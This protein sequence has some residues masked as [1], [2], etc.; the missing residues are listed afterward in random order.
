ME[1]LDGFGVYKIKCWATAMVYIGG[2]SVSF[3]SRKVKHWQRLRKGIHENDLLQASWNKYGEQFFFFEIIVR[4]DDKKNVKSQEKIF[5]DYYLKAEPQ[6]CYNLSASTTGGNTITNPYVK[7]KHHEGLIRSYTDELRAK[8][9][10]QGGINGVKAQEKLKILRD[11]P[12]YKEK[13]KKML[14]DLAKNPEWLAKMKVLSA[15]RKVKVQTDKG[16][17]FDSV[18]EAASATGATRSSIRKCI[19]GIYKTCAG[20][21]WS[22]RE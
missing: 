8:R 12:E 9:S 21:K 14:Q 4:V 7:K 6:N 10:I 22:Y 2:T 3:S 15:A 16:E 1:S 20:R 11:T 17:I 18:T 19:K 13:N 5:L